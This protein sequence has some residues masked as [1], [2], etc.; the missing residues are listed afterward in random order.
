[1]Y[2]Q[3]LELPFGNQTWLAEKSLVYREVYIWEIHLEI[4][5]FNACHV[6]LL[7][8]GR[9]LW[10]Y[11]LRPKLDSFLVVF[12]WGCYKD[13]E[14]LAFVFQS[15]LGYIIPEIGNLLYIGMLVI[16]KMLKGI[17]RGGTT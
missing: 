1:M 17:E 11:Q 5:D 16:F 13:Y 3:Q 15:S 12:L 6:C 2:N 9:T 10:H 8:Q 14:S 7:R 4:G